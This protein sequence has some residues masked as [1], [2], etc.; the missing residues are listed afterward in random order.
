MRNLV[1][2]FSGGETSAYMTHL[3][4]SK[5]RAWY[6][7]VVVVFANT[8]QENEETLNFVYDCDRWMGFNTVW[9]EAEVHAEAKQGTTHRTVTFETASGDGEPYEAVIRKYGI[10]NAKFPH[11]TRELKERP[12]KSYIRSLGWKPGSYDLA[13]GIRADEARRADTKKRELMY[14]LLHWEP[15]TKEMISE[16][17][18][19]QSFRLYLEGYRGNCRWCWKKSTRKLTRI[20][21]ETPEVFE[22]PARMEAEYGLVGP[23][24]AKTTAPGYRRTF[25]RGNQSVADLRELRVVDDRHDGCEES[26]EVVW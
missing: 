17:W 9:V 1:I 16:F 14:P 6:R 26:C 12:I 11:C 7:E 23:E 22:F 2:S 4:L 24:F 10:P 19:K 3:L 20:M 5:Y 15:T 8:G 13:I 21:A 25:F 18:A